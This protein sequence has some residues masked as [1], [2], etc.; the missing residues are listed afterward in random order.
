MSL[1]L[2]PFPVSI[3]KSNWDCFEWCF[4]VVLSLLCRVRT[5]HVFKASVCSAVSALGQ[6]P[7]C[8]FMWTAGGNDLFLSLGVC[9]IT[10]G[11]KLYWHSSDRHVCHPVNLEDTKAAVLFLWQAFLPCFLSLPLALSLHHI[12]LSSLSKVRI[13]S[14]SRASCQVLHLEIVMIM[15][16]C[17]KRPSWCNCWDEISLWFPPSR[18][19]DL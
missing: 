3:Y 17:P 19:H 7:D 9:P 1:T 16:N 5:V 14:D 12:S 4:T 6:G 13:C 2:S 15:G 11:P 8:G 10:R 18:F